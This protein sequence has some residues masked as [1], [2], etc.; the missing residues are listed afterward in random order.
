[1]TTPSTTAQVEPPAAA[2][3]A[4]DATF[5]ARR[6]G[7]VNLL[8]CHA[9]QPTGKARKL[10]RI[11]VM[12]N[13]TRATGPRPGAV[14]HLDLVTTTQHT[15]AENHVVSGQRLPANLRERR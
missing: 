14:N 15:Y 3:E 1:V 10:M 2:G 11:F 12:P 6:Y 13:Q 7:R 5:A 4:F 8:I 9:P